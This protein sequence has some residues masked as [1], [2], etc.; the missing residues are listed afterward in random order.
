MDNSAGCTAVLK[1]LE[2][3]AGKDCPYTVYAVFATREEMGKQGAKTAL[4]GVM[5]DEALVTD[6][7]FACAPGIP[8]ESSAKQGSG[9]MIGISPILQKD[10]SDALT[11]YAPHL[12]VI[13]VIFARRSRRR[14]QIEHKQ[15]S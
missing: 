2:Q 9:A 3:L 1:A 11:G 12:I 13:S 14:L 4:F 6:V 7:S 10:M 15:N 5:P 8:E